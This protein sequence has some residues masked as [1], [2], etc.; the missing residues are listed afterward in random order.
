MVVFRS[1]SRLFISL[2]SILSLSAGVSGVAL[3]E[4]SKQTKSEPW[5]LCVPCHG[6]GGVSIASNIPNLAG[7]KNRYLKKQFLEFKKRKR[8]NDRGQMKSMANKVK[9]R[10]VDRILTYFSQS[11]PAWKLANTENNNINSNDTALIKLGEELYQ[12]GSKKR[13]SC[14]FCHSNSDHEAPWLFGQKADYVVKQLQDF[15]SKLR[16]NDNWKQMRIVAE[17]LTDREIEALGAYLERA[18]PDPKYVY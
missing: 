10:D 4:P 7:Q 8:T 2:V 12:A 3:A 5:D 15:K 18:K 11:T 16:A 17:Q 1:F 14:K 13:V 9:A 6:Q